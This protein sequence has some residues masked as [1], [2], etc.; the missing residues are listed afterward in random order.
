MSLVTEEKTEKGTYEKSLNT[1]W[2][3]IGI[4]TNVKGIKETRVT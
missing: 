4:E 1:K 2:E 3:D